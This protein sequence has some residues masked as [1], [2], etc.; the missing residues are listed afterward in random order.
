MSGEPSGWGGDVGGV[1][2]TQTR[3]AAYS[4]P[5]PAA[6]G[7]LPPPQ[8]L[9]RISPR[10]LHPSPDRSPPC[11]HPA[12]RSPPSTLSFVPS[13]LRTS[14]PH[15]PP[16]HFLSLLLRT[17]HSHRT[18][19]IS[20][21][22]PAAAHAGAPPPSVPQRAVDVHPDIRA[23]SF[24]SLGREYVSPPMADYGGAGIYGGAVR[25]EP[26]D[27]DGR[28]W[29]EGRARAGIGEQAEYEPRVYGHG[30]WAQIEARRGHIDMARGRIGTS[31]SG[32]RC[33]RATNTGTA[34]ADEMTRAAVPPPPCPIPERVLLMR[35]PQRC[36]PL[37]VDCGDPCAGGRR[38][39]QTEE[40]IRMRRGR[41]PG[42]GSAASALLHLHYGRWTRG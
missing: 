33:L 28:V 41:P 23:A 22:T 29:V 6:R 11:V 17:T 31:G 42:A 19:S 18:Y 7:R 26:T 35:V 21:H 34:G 32:R 25:P 13:A 5:P 3:D 36:H 16:P 15:L 37:P 1:D 27:A 40:R 14:S 9:L 4:F 24:V 2:M 38:G 12:S 20:A 30:A 39:A 10:V 8:R